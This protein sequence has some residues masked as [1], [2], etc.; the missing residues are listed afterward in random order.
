[1]V[2]ADFRDVA[3]SCSQGRTLYFGSA[4]SS[5]LLHSPADPSL[6][7]FVVPIISRQ[8]PLVLRDSQVPFPS[9]AAPLAP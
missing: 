1:M 9:L 4:S 3:W 8:D 2:L 7:G 6:W 5:S